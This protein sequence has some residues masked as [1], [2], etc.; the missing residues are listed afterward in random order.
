MKKVMNVILMAMLSMLVLTSMLGCSK[1]SSTATAVETNRETAKPVQKYDLIMGTA[2]TSG[3]YYVVGAAMGASV[4]KNSSTVNVIVQP[5]KGSIENLNL[6]NTDDIQLGFSNSDGVYWAATGTGNYV[7]TGK[8]KI[9]AIMNLYRSQGQMVTLKNSGIKTY[10]D[11]KGKKVNLGPSGQTVVEISKTILR[12]Y[13]IDPEK[14]ITPLYL[15]VDEGLGKLKDGEIDA[16]FFCAAYPAAGVV[17]IASTTEVRLVD[18]DDAVLKQV[19]TANPF[20]SYGIIPANTYKGQTEDCRVV[21]MVTELFASSA[22]PEAAI[23]EFVKQALETQ[24]QYVDAHVSIKEIT[25]QFAS[26]CVTELHPGAL[27]YYTEKGLR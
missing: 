26:Q 8:L 9:Q 1:K 11:L 25:P 20:Y 27:K 21:E 4:N 16:S 18:I 24:S 10:G 6:A 5:T 3:T 19:C 23:Y 12:A 14:D 13:G 17:N 2:G 15:A 7:K 22:A